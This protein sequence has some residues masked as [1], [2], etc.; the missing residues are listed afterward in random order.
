MAKIAVLGAGA[1]GAALALTLARGDHSVTLAARRVAY[2]EEIRRTGESSYL[3]GVPFPP[4]VVL[5]DRWDEAAAHAEAIVVAVPSRHVRAAIEP[6]ASAFPAGAIVISVTKG[7]APGSLQTMSRML[8]EI[9]PPADR[10]AVLSGPGFAPEVARG[11]P[12]A[13][14]AAAR[15][16]AV[17]ASVQKLFANRT[18]RVYRSSD[19]IGVELGG[20]VK[21]VIAIAAGISDGLELGSSA[22]AAL[23]TRGLAE[24]M[25]L[26]AA[27]GARRETMAGLA[28]LG[29]LLLTCT[30]DLSRNRALG[31]ALG[32]G[33]APSAPADGA[34]VPEGASNARSVRMLA[35]RMD[36]EMPI[37]AAVARV[38]YEG[39]SANAMVDEL[40]RRE[41]K[42]EF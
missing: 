39:A 4:D 37:V 34:P 8:A 21:N 10:I 25:R 40:L 14:V 28:G 36:V 24:M 6:I 41:L 17:A 16:H 30:G 26:A 2:L 35:A 22:R 29:D 18:L 13:L 12:A 7:I 27:A 1:W 20:A 3:P 15:N 38:L 31:I 42:A 11:L 23:I 33:G 5:T 19:V 32:R 9:A